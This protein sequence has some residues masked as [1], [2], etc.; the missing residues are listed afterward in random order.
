[1]N[2]LADKLLEIIADYRND[3]GIYLDRDHIIVWANQFG[4]DAEFILKEMLHVIP[5]VY[6]S[7]RKAKSLLESH[8]RKLMY[9]FGYANVGDLLIN[10]EF[11]DLQPALKSQSVILALLEEVL[12]EKYG[13]SYENYKSYPKL[14]F[15]YFDYILASGSTIGNQIEK[16]LK[17][18]GKDGI[19]NSE[20]I[21]TNKYRLSINLFGLHTW[22]QSF[23]RF[24]IIKVFDDK[25][26]KKIAWI[27]DYEIQN[28]AKWRNQ[29]FN[30]AFRIEEQP[31]VVKLYLANLDALKYEDYAYRN[32]N[33]PAIENFFSTAENRV[34]YENIILQKGLSIITM[35]QGG[36]KPNIRPLG[37]TNPSYK[38]FGLGTH[39]FTWRNIPNNSP[40]IFW[41][42]VP[43]HNWKPLFPVVNRG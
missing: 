42:E 23:Q 28:H 24:R 4:N 18:E 25:I 32:S 35:I 9:H 29:K 33:A 39:F 37:L 19:S 16:W 22:G 2:D 7:K 5:Q 17:E 40:L 12:A 38:T 30:I 3:D 11:L 41:W 26:D 43:G 8:I 36:I 20:H 1:M 10:T 13:E 6:I 21:L 34:K 14:N 15:V 31:A 27:Y